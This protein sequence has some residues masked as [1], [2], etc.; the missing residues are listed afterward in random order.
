MNGD[1]PRKILDEL[2]NMGVEIAIDDFGIGYSSLN[3]L[4]HFSIHR[5]KIDRSFTSAV[6]QDPNNIAIS[7]AIIAL[8]KSLGLRVIA[9][10]IETAEQRDFFQREGCDDGQGYL[11]S[12]PAP[13]E[14]I[15]RLLLAK[16]SAEVSP[17]STLEG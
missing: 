14:E 8:A 5:L 16:P 17:H 12:K 11:F 6:P 13:P 1:E 7:R 9:E 4:K 15:E 10:G 3:Y 2:R